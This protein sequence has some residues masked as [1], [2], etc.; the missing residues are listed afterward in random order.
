MKTLIMPNNLSNILE[1]QNIDG[2]IIG[3]KNFS[4]YVP[5]ETSIDDLEEIVLKLKSAKKEIFISLNKLMYNED[6]PLL[7]EYLL[8]IDKLNVDGIMYDD[9]AILNLSKSM[10]LKTPLV[11]FGV[12]SFTNGKTANY[13][14]TKGVKRGVLSTEITLD[15]IIEIKNETTME[16]MMYGYGYLPMFVSSRPLLSSYFEHIGLNKEDKIYH[17]WEKDRKMSYPTYETPHG[18]IIL[19]AEILNTVNELKTISENVNYLILS[20]LNIEHKQFKSICNH[21][22]DAINNIND[23]KITDEMSKMVTEESPA[24]TDKGFLYK[25]T[26]Y[27]VKNDG[28]R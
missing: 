16:L 14:L 13:W 25:E 2:V 11:W 21:Y 15:H 18:T 12:H 4:W 19:S 23:K 20:S 10:S 5:F 9:L 22:L 24:R 6:I 17:M 8:V 28:E 27:R 3:V 26:V 1:F 7:K